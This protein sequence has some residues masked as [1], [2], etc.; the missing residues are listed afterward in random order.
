MYDDVNH[1]TMD[2]GSKHGG[3]LGRVWV[4]CS[5]QV[6]CRGLGQVLQ[7][8]G[9]FH[10]GEE[11]PSWEEAQDLTIVVGSGEY[12]AAEVARTRREFP[13]AA[14]VLLCWDVDLQTAR[15]ALRSGARGIIYMDMP[16]SQMVRSLEL[17]ERGE[18]VVP[19]RLLTE[20][21]AGEIQFV[22]ISAL[23]FRQRQILN[24]VEE[25]ASNAQIASKLFLSEFTVKQ[26]LR[27]AYKVLGVRNRTEAAHIVRA[28][29]SSELLAQPAMHAGRTPPE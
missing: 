8:S 23:T 2:R 15:S 29:H 11:P 18:L 28:N 6:V 16:P 21:I 26:H 20:M 14:V 5:Q 10:F 24:L 1:S 9:S 25:G 17:A 22:D 3:S 27:A 19:R 7:G 4:R 13:E 12:G